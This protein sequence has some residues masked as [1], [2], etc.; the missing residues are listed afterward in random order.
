MIVTS[1]TLNIAGTCIII[2]L[3]FYIACQKS[4]VSVNNLH[5]KINMLNVT[6]MKSHVNIIY[7]A[8][9]ENMPPYFLCM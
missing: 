3:I 5:V 6:L 9:A 4:H 8:W 7:L 2:F 1:D